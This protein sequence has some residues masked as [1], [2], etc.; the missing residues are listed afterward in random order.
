M[1]QNLGAAMENMSGQMRREMKNYIKEKDHTQF[2]YL[3][4]GMVSINVTHS[5]LK[6]EMIELKLDLHMTIFDVKRKLHTHCG[7]P[8]VHQRLLLRDN[9]QTLALLADDSKMLGYYSVES[10][11]VI[12]VDDTDPFSLSRGGALEDVSLV[13][14]YRMTDDDYENRR[15]TVREFIREKKAIDPNWTPP[16]AGMMTGNPW[17]RQERPATDGPATEENFDAESVAGLEVGGR[18]E[19]MPGARRGEIAY[20]GERGLEKGFWVGVRFDEPMGK[21]DGTSKGTRY[22]ECEPSFGSFVR[23]KNVTMGDFP[24]EGF[25]DDSEDEI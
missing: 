24:E 11:M 9:G 16:T 7:T 12:H 23:G 14:R 2:A 18:C 8:A 6:R 4:Q 15:G 19:V 13:E 1:T 10:G 3:P 21:G 25:D 20:I 17:Q 5:N 22:F